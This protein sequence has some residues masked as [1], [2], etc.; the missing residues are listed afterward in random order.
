[1]RKLLKNSLH[2]LPMWKENGRFCICRMLKMKQGPFWVAPKSF[3][4]IKECYENKKT[5]IISSITPKKS[6]IFQW[7][8]LS[9]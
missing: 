9:N 8:Q 2:N 4:T 5:T 6:E 7:F 3:L 1:M